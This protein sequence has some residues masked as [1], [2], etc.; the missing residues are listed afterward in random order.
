[1]MIMKLKIIIGKELNYLK[2]L[3][4]TPNGIVEEIILNPKLLWDP[5]AIDNLNNGYLIKKIFGKERSLIMY[6]NIKII[7]DPIIWPPSIDTL[8]FTKILIENRY[9]KKRNTDRLLD[10]GCGTGFLGLYFGKM[11]KNL[12]YVILSDINYVA[13]SISKINSKLNKISNKVKIICGDRFSFFKERNITFDCILCTPPYIPYYPNTKNKKMTA[14]SGTYL[15]RTSISQGGNYSN[16]LVLLYS[17]IAEY[18][19]QKELKKINVKSEILST[20]QFPFRV[21]NILF[22]ESWLKYLIE[23]RNLR[24]IEKSEYKYWH[25]LIIRKIEY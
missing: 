14:F 15:L 17:N 1:M 25:K 16:E 2:Y 5:I 13:C 6:D 24:K 9:I 23:K 12:D 8:W 4:N 10:L 20:C 22:N 19:V 11:I 7:W 18:E 3:I 21:P